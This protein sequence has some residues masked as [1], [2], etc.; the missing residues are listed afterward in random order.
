MEGGGEG[1]ELV[2]VA[3]ANDPIEAEM[4]HGLLES[5]GIPSLTGRR[6]LDGPLY[7]YGALQPGFDGG[8]RGVMVPAERAEQARALLAETLAEN[9]G[10]AEDEVEI[11]DLA[12]ARY[13][14][15]RGRKPRSYGL[16]GAYARIYLWSFAFLVV[17]FGVFLLLRA[18]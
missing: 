1:G 18:A 12:N 14:E 11:S 15:G 6:G 9:E 3:F 5:A 2:Q 17:A 13:L 16:G 4:I 7:G 8:S 10:A